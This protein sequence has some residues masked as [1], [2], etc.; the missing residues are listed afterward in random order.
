MP[1]CCVSEF[2]HI[3]GD[4]KDITSY[5]PSVRPLKTCLVLGFGYTLLHDPF[6]SRNILGI[7]VAIVGMGLYS[8]FCTLETKKKQPGDHSAPQVRISFI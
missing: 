5:I 7:L 6:T 1:D 3:F 4:W 2:Q 8:Y